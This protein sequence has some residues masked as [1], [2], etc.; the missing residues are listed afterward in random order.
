MQAYRPLDPRLVKQPNDSAEAKQSKVLLHQK[1]ALDRAK[2]AI[3]VGKMFRKRHAAQKKAK[4]RASGKR[5]CKEPTPQLPILKPSIK[6]AKY[7]K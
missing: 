5:S 1:E 2:D 6:I 3:K 4:K 7:L